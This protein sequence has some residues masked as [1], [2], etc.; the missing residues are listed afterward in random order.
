MIDL[1]TE[2][3]MSL[4]QAARWAPPGRRGSPTS[5]PCLLRWILHGSRDPNGELVKLEALRL[6][7]RWVTTREAIQ[8]F[9][10]RLTPRID[11]SG[12]SIS[13]TS[14][15]SRPRRRMRRQQENAIARAEREL[16]KLGVK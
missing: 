2:T 7:G 10:E 5:L 16:D 9:A 6:G 12:S 15:P 11:D 3:P 14:S 8:R 1:T 4:S 13:T